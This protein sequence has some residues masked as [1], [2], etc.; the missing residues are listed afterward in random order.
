MIQTVLLKKGIIAQDSEN[1][2]VDDLVVEKMGE[3]YTLNEYAH[4]TAIGAALK[5]AIFEIENLKQE[6]EN[7]KAKKVK[8]RI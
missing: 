6:I 7:L 3:H 2:N 1:N 4:A 8:K 5:Q